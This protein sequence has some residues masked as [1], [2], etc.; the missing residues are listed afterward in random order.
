METGF[1]LK[2]YCREN[3]DSKYAT[4]IYFFE[5]AMEPMEYLFFLR[6]LEGQKKMES[7]IDE[8]RIYKDLQR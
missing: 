2:M 8:F 5:L 1:P 3:A 7:Y 6:D 4:F